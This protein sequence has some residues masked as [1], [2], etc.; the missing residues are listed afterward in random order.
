VLH[1]VSVEVNVLP[2]LAVVR[3]GY[4]KLNLMLN[5]PRT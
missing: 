4:T 2:G 1:K 5:N 3:T